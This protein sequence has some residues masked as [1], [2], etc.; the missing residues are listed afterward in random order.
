[1]HSKC[2]NDAVSKYIAI[3]KFSFLTEETF[4]HL[5]FWNNKLKNNKYVIRKTKMNMFKKIFYKSR[6]MNI[7]EVNDKCSFIKKTG[8]SLYENCRRHS[9]N[10]SCRKT[11]LN[12]F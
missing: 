6:K 2:L 1:M 8:F 12:F 3:K 5:N 10:V 11:S 9:L 7:I 4:Q